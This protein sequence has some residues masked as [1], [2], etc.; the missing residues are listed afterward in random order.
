VHGFSFFDGL[1]GALL[2]ESA[3]F[4]NGIHLAC[5]VPTMV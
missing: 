5:P 4:A 1:D 2:S 3:E